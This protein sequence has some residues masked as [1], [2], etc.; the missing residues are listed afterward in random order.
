MNAMISTFIVALGSFASSHVSLLMMLAKA[1]IILIA[2]LGIT[3][4][5]GRASAGSG[6]LVWFV[7]LGMLLLVPALSTWARL[8][9]RILPAA[10]SD[11]GAVP[12]LRD[13]P[14]VAAADGRVARG[15]GADT[16]GRHRESAVA[17]GG[18]R[19][20]GYARRRITGAVVRA[21]SRVVRSDAVPRIDRSI[22]A[23]DAASRRGRIERSMAR[24][25]CVCAARQQEAG[26]PLAD[27]RTTAR[28]SQ[29][30][31]NSRGARVRQVSRRFSLLRAG[32]AVH[33]C[34]LSSRTLSSLDL[35]VRD[36]TW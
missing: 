36:Q 11:V 5:M 24:R 4:S 1:T 34:A 25:A 2:A 20:D 26:A 29:R 35:D 15:V 13:D 33:V 32:N 10:T 12:S 27:A 6:H 3:V 8:P 18:E 7:T 21:R 30:A 31:G 14:S 28:L 22:R 16:T 9:L 19:G 23:W 17:H